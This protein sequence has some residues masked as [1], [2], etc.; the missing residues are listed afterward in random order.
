M[1][2]ESE[3]IGE[4]MM[5]FDSEDPVPPLTLEFSLGHCKR[6]RLEQCISFSSNLEHSVL[7][8]G[9]WHLATFPDKFGKAG[10]E[11]MRVST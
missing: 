3:L 2:F 8:L 7:L 10:S 5:A 1:R 6:K 4:L 11:T 9:K